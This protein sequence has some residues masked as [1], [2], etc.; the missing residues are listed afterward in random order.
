VDRARRGHAAG[1]R[2]LGAGS[3]SCTGRG[4]GVRGA[5]P[6][7]IGTLP[8]PN[9][10]R[11]R[12]WGAGSPQPAAPVPGG[13]DGRADRRD[14]AGVERVMS[15]HSAYGGTSRPRASTAT[16]GR[17]TCCGTARAGLAGRPGRARRA[18][19]DRLAL[20]GL[21]GGVPHYDRLLDALPRVVARWPTGGRSASRC[22]A[23][24]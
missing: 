3:P 17:A 18:P 2:A 21:W 20:L 15:E 12:P 11:P 22:T 13:L 19:R 5:W 7:Y 1:R 6:G 23:C 4:A 14:I 10:S 8:L 9:T 24:T 16:C